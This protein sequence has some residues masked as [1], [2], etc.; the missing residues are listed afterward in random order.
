M[1]NKIKSITLLFFISLVTIFFLGCPGAKRDELEYYRGKVDSLRTL[2][3]SFVIEYN[4]LKHESYLENQ[5]FLLVSLYQKYNSLF[6]QEDINLINNLLK[7]EQRPE[8]IDRLERLKVFIYEKIVEKQTAGLH[9]RIELT[10]YFINYPYIS[11]GAK[12]DDLEKVLANEPNAQRRK[13]IYNSNERFFEE[14]KKVN[15]KLLRSRNEIIIDSLRFGSYK[16]FAS[17]V[18]QENI[19][20][21][22][23]T[24]RD[25]IS[26]TNDFYFQQ[27]YE[28]LRLRKFAQDKFYAY[29]MPYLMRESRLAKYFKADS[30]NKIFINSYHNAGFAIDSLPN[31]KITFYQKDKRKVKEMKDLGTA[32]FEISIPNE[33]YLYISQTGGCDNYSAMFS[34]SAKLFPSIFSKEQIFEFNYFGG[35]LL[36]LTYKNLFSNLLDEHEY[37]ELNMFHS[38]LLSSEFLKFR[39]FRKLF[40]LRKLCADFITEYLFIDSLQTNIDSLAQIYNSIL[41]FN[42]TS[43]DKSRMLLSLNDYFY[44]VELINSIFLEAMMKTKIREKFGNQWFNNQNLKSYLLKFIER[45]R[46]LTKDKFLIEIGYYNLDPRFFF[47][48]II[49]M[50]ERSKSTLRR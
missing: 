34:E 22:Y 30:V 27:L 10:K 4:K 8:R 31:L 41:G 25:F 39:A 1:K 13:Y 14:I 37:L 5:P 12:F 19:D 15:L 21:F 42:L 6:N 26:S 23:Q 40:A 16:Q 44:E 17:M 48:E 38:N 11:G 24:V 2:V 45:G 3:N 47:N 50:T 7:L 32:G 33:N 28:L 18:R 46:F 9:D 35:D 36:P 20:K 49:S 29:D 43:G